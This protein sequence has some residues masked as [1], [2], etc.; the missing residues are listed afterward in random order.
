MGCKILKV[1]LLIFI[2]KYFLFVFILVK[3]KQNFNTRMLPQ[4]FTLLR[5]PVGFHFPSSGICKQESRK[6]N[7]PA[8]DVNICSGKTPWSSMVLPITAKDFF[9]S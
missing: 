2:L 9:T 4:Y 1:L 3:D 6:A 8:K 5:F 7:W